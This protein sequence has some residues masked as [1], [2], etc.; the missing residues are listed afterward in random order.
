M[1]LLPLEGR[2]RDAML[3]LILAWGVLDGA[4][5][6]LLSAAQGLSL[7]QGAEKFGRSTN[8]DKLRKLCRWLRELPSGGDTANK[9]E[10]HRTLYERYSE[11]RNCIAHAKCVGV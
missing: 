11:P 5:G 2:H 1:N 7:D 4:L 8:P 3:D 6:M 9:L 10:T